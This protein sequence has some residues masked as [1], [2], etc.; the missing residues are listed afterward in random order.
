MSVEL[1]PLGVSCNIACQYCYQHPQRD[2]ADF[3]KSYDLEAMKSAV[4]RE[5][6]GFTLFGGEALLVPLADL[7]RLWAWGLATFGKNAL[8][9]NGTLITD[10]H[11][12][13]F[14]KYKVSVGISVDGP[15]ALNDVRWAGTL[16]RTRKHTAATQTNI[17]RLCA[18]NMAPSIIITLHRG[19]ALPDKLPA[20]EA[21]LKKLDSLGVRSARL[22]L[23]EVENERLRGAYHLNTDEYIKALE[24]FHRLESQC[25]HL[26]FDIFTEIG[27]LQKAEDQTVSCVWKAC[28]PYTTAAVSGVEGFGQR[29]NCGRTNKEGIDFVKATVPG[30]ARYIA[31]YHTPQEMGGCRDCRF[32]AMCKGH[33]PG[34]SLE[35]DWRNRTEHCDVWKY[36]F[37]KTERGML[38]NGETP[39][40]THPVRRT[41]EKALLDGWSRG[42]NPSIQTILAQVLEN[43]RTAARE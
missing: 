3:S 29:S 12:D 9:T 22:H 7:E 36:L 18:L 34:T 27:R 14:T 24:Y 38:E 21:W 15:E 32:F 31:L 41:V 8:Q 19:N 42:R 25:T 16:E 37:E 13:L 40:S 30:Y 35:G 26:R 6:G 17:E 33:C 1:R 11:I 5:G 43:Q 10:A 4:L 39:L 2:V 28:D 23:M 20:M